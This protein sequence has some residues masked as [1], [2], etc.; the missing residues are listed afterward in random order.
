VPTAVSVRLVF[1]FILF[2]AVF[3]TFGGGQMI[4]DLSLALTGARKGGPAKAAVLSSGLMGSVSGSAVANVMSTGIFTIPLMKR[5]KYNPLFAAGVEAV[6]STGGQIM[7]PV[8]GAAAFVMADY[9]QLPY[10]KVVIA[11]VLPALLYFICILICVDLE[12]RRQDLPLI[13][14]KDV[15][16]VWQTLKTSGHMLIPLVWLVYRIVAGFDVT[17]LM[18]EVILLTI[19]IGTLRPSSRVGGAQIIMSF[20]TAAQRSI[21]VAVPCALASL[22]VSV[23]AFTGLGTK[24]TSIILAVAGDEVAIMLV[25]AMVATL[26]LGA[27]MPTTS[28]YIMGAVLIAPALIEFGMNPVI[29][30]FFVFYFAIMSMLTPPVALSAYAA[31]TIAETS[32]AKT[33]WQ[34]L[35]LALPGFIIPYAFVIH[36]G[37]LLIGPIEGTLLGLFS[38][39]I[40]LICVAIAVTGWFFKPLSMAERGLVMVAAAGALWPDAKISLTVCGVLILGGIWMFLRRE[41]PDGVSGTSIK[42]TKLAKKV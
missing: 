11:A 38:V 14:K 7:P 35:R 5:I 9:L 32:P 2:A 29:C 6:A 19:A 42:R 41:V 15:P 37:L 31:A 16:G 36:P 24:F 8:M 39:I 21:N 33:G 12:A 40:G 13:E 22:I 25:L 10:G 17:T 18:I 28:A 1:Y 20:V 30:H 27:G 26:I 4:I 34:A 23:I 3:E